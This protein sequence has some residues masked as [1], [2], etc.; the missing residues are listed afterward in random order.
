MLKH[1]FD[2]NSNFYFHIISIS[3]FA[4]LPILIIFLLMI[5]TSKLV[6]KFLFLSNYTKFCTAIDSVPTPPVRGSALYF[7]KRSLQRLTNV[8]GTFT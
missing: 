3:R 7:Y 6:N 2:I 1:F 8:K 4:F 5:I